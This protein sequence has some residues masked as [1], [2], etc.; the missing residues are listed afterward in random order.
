VLEHV[1]IADI[2]AGKL[3]AA[4]V[5]MTKDRDAWLPR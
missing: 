5:G 4:V 1:T 3:P 2:V